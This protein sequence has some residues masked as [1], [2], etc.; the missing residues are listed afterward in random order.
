MLTSK[1]EAPRILSIRSLGRS[2]DSLV[3]EGSVNGT[4]TTFTVDTGA[5]VSLIRANTVDARNILPLSRRVSLRTV[6]GDSANVYGE[7]EVELRLGRMK[8]YHR[9]LVADIEDEFILG[10]DV[11]KQHGFTFDNKL[12]ILKLGT[13][14]FVLSNTIDEAPIKVKAAKMFRISGNSEKIIFGKLEKNSGSCVGLVQHHNQNNRLLI[15][16]SLVSSTGE[17]PIRVAN[18]FPNN[19]KINKD[20]EIAIFEPVKWVARCEEDDK[21]PSERTSASLKIPEQFLKS[22]EH[23]SLEDQEK[24]KQFVTEHSGIFESEKGNTG[25]TNVI[26]HQINTGTAYPIRQPPRRLPVAKHQEVQSLVDKM[27]S[28]GVIEESSSPW[29]S[30]VVLVT[31]KDGTT[32]FCV[33]YRKLNDVTKK[34]SYPLPRIDDTLSTLAGSQWFSTLDLKSGYWQVGIHEQ[35]KEKT[36]F[37]TGTGLYHFNVMPFGLCNA[38]ATFE[39]LMEI[40]LRGLTWKTCLVYLDDVMV[41]GKTFDEHLDNLREVFSRISKAHLKL[42]PKKCSLFQKRVE[43]LGHV[44]SP[45]GIHTDERKIDAIRNWP[46]PR[47]KHELRSFL[48]LCTYYRR[49][50]EGFASIAA[51]LHKLTEDKAAYQWNTDCEQSFRKLKASLCSSPILGYPEQQGKFILDTDASNTGIGAVLSQVQNGE[52]RVIEYYSRVLSKPERNY[53]VTRKELLAIVKSVNHFHKYLYGQEFLVR[54]DHAALKWLMEMK[55]PEG[56]IARWLEKLQQYHFKIKHR[57]GKLHNNADALSRRPCKEECKHCL[58]VEQ[59][60][61]IITIRRTMFSENQE[62]TTGQLRDAQLKDSDI[63]PFLRLKENNEARPSWTDISEKGLTFKALWAQWDSLLIENGLLKRAWE[64]A[65]GKELKTQLIVPKEKISEV[66]E[67]MHGG[68]SGAHL[69][70][71]KTLEKIRNRFYWV[72]YC[73]DVKSWCRQCSKCAASQGHN[74][75]SKGKM[76]KYNVGLPFERIAIDVAGPFPMTLKGNKYILV[77]MDYF[78]KWPEVFAIPNQEASTIADVLVENVFS[79]FGVPMELHSDQGRNF[80]SKLFQRLCDLMGIHKTRTTALHPQSDGMVE[81]FNKTIEDHLSKVVEGHQQDWDQYLPLFLMAYR[82]AVHDTTGMTPAM[83]LFGRELRL[84][85][86]ILFGC[87]DREPSNV[88]DYTDELR[89]KLL[90]IHEL[91]R[92]K[93]D[94]ASD[95]MKTRYDLKANSTGFHQGDKVWL[96]NPQRKKGISPKLTPAWEGPYVVVKRINDVVYR[97]QRSPKSKMKVVHLDRLKAYHTSE[98]EADR[99]DQR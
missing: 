43:F 36:A 72:N 91:V 32:R 18:I 3:I 77:V 46:R 81:R 5:V 34:D 56:Q 25:R 39:R 16:R 14:E 6:T 9:V 42:N 30:P 63:E 24:A 37:S 2:A 27:L 31:K 4:P 60:E 87:P 7:M 75:R 74:T 8:L 54:T 95:R 93:M 88:E 57:P 86:D 48:G 21:L 20:D 15:A 76:R 55:Q 44:V 96:W 70:V 17:I 83:V 68:K 61:G 66:L 80:E 33:D 58:R 73:Q 29:S 40:V 1:D 98:R 99:D 23:L 13:E 26:Q 19:V 41:M 10:M 69:G 35:D 97:I 47:D 53:C 94:I 78:S 49:F 67:E 52:E 79:R 62:W 85:C 65:D 82:S 11:I 71:N 22:W 89:E 84:P 51:P 92:K 50:V 59:R 64:S 12:N 28:D 90:D 38:P 45:E